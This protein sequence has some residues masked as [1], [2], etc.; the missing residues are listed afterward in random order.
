MFNALEIAAS[1]A[2]PFSTIFLAELGD[3]SQI[4]CMTLAACHRAKP[5]LFGALSAFAILNLLAVTVGASLAYLIPG[6][7]I[8]Y[9]AAGLFFLFGVLAL[10]TKEDDEEEDLKQTKSSHG[11]FVTTFAMIFL[12]ELGDKTQIAVMTLSTSYSPALIWVLAT[13]ALA[14]TAG[15][16]I[17]AGRKLLTRINVSLLHKISGAFFI[18]LA[19]LLVL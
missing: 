5:V 17:F 19:G 16:G 7:T 9:I 14:A 3:K 8:T 13:L 1:S 4:V 10:F 2:I 11:L 15:L 12:A 6:N 18:L